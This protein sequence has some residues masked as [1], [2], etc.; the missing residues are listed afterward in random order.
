MDNFNSINDVWKEVMAVCRTKV[1]EIMFNL[2]IAPLEPVKFILETYTV[3]F[4]ISNEFK[5]SITLDKFRGVIEESFCEVMGFPVEIDII[6]SA[7]EVIDN[8]NAAKNPGTQAAQTEKKET[9]APE[10]GSAAGRFTFDN[11]IVGKSNMF[12][13][14][15]SMGVA[16]QPGTLHN[17]LL[18]YGRSGLGKTH[19]ML[20]IYNKIK[21]DNPDMVIIYTTGEEFMN[22]L[23][24]S[25]SSKN[26]K[27]FHDKYR[28]VD[29][30][31]MDDIQVIQKGLSTQEEFFHT[32][33]ALQLAGKQIVLT[34]D[35]PAKEME[36][37]EERIRTRLEQGMMADIQP[38]DIDTRK[39]I[40]LR[41]CQQLGITLNDAII[42]YIATKIKNNVRQ[43]EG[44]VKKAAA[45]QTAFNAPITMEQIEDIIRDITTDNQPTPVLVE[46]IIEYIA[47]EFELQPSVLKSKNRK[48]EIVTA[49]DVTMYVIKEV[50]DL[51]LAQ[52]GKYFDR[53][54]SSVLQAI[55]E[56]E[57]KMDEYPNA[58]AIAVKAI[59]DFQTKN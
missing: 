37:L 40:V 4:S 11:F 10:D 38:P 17:P 6:V 42:N 24:Y 46:K 56:A 32:F 22:D 12:A 35:V 44:T 59:G 26:T 43:L 55:R 49:R 51:T 47:K 23:V 30:L 48:E 34:S 14:T 2:W 9:K 15:V 16:N 41:K 33:D 54:H 28:N 3:V 58:K 18:I 5:K 31:L 39:A 52:I 1:S 27:A 36:V 25:L 57:N 13:Y 21:H 29:A 53:N 19:L 50:T 45:M 8:Y 7:N 20:A